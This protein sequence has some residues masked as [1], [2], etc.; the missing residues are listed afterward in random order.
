MAYCI[1][2]KDGRQ[3]H[4]VHFLAE[5]DSDLAFI[6][7][8]CEP[9]STVEVLKDD[10]KEAHKFIKSPS[11][12]WVLYEGE[13]DYKPPKND[14]KVSV[15]DPKSAF[16]LD[17]TKKI[18]DYQRDV[19]IYQSGLVTG[20]LLEQTVPDDESIYT[21]DQCKGHYFTANLE[22]PEGA[23]HY[24][25]YTEGEKRKDNIPCDGFLTVRYENMSAPTPTGKRIKVVYDT[26]E[27]FEFAL[28]GLKVE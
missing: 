24:S 11:D 10:D 25:I 4:I 27:E 1:L 7:D 23:Q 22:T 28:D 20:T 13:S 14:A 9:G 12:K 19:R 17:K 21:G 15:P 3:G 6:V 2:S 26:G 8:L 18:E 5:S 16:T